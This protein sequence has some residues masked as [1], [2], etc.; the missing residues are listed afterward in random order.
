M[1]IKALTVMYLP[2]C[3]GL[4]KFGHMV[5]KQQY[6]GFKH[7]LLYMYIHVNVFLLILQSVASQIPCG[8]TVELQFDAKMKIY[9]I[10]CFIMPCFKYYR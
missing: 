5:A 7:T 3:H 8:H 1:S 4:K 10:F 2:H 9:F 6:K